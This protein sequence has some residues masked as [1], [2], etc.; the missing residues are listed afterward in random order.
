M[1]I[2]RADQNTEITEHNTEYGYGSLVSVGTMEHTQ[3]L[4]MED[5]SHQEQQRTP[6]RRFLS[7]IGHIKRPSW[8]R[9]PLENNSFVEGSA[10]LIEQ[11]DSIIS[12]EENTSNSVRTGTPDFLKFFLSSVGPPQIV[13]LCMLWALALGSTIGVVP[14]VLTDQYAKIYHNFDSGDS[15]SNYA[16][17]DKPHACLDGSSDAQTAAASASFVSNTFTFITSSLIGSISDEHGRRYLL[18]LGNF[19]ALLGPVSLVYIQTFPSSNPNWYYVA[20]SAG[21]VVSWISLA[22]SSLSDVMPKQWRAPTFGLLL[23][24]FSVGFALSPVLALGFSHY[25]VSLLSLSLLIGGFFYSLFY[26]PETLSPETAEA[27]RNQRSEYHRR[28]DESQMRCFLRTLA[29]PM[30]ELSILNRNNLFRLLSSLAFFSGMTSSADQTLLLYYVEDRLDFNDHDVAVMFGLIGLLGIFVQG[31]M[32]KPFTDLIGERLV[33]VVAF[34]MGA[35]TNALYAYAPS[36]Q[37]IFLA[38]CISSFGGMSFPTI[39]AIKANNAEEFEQGRIQGALYALSSLASA[40][41][42]CLLRLGY[43][44]TKDTSQPGAFFLIGSIFFIVATFCGWA[45]PKDKANSTQRGTTVE[46]EQENEEP[47]LSNS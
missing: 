7:G 37:Y 43:Q 26:L 38:V 35:I 41:G 31:F 24:G 12:E 34:I 30:K 45:L 9:A 27:A 8:R 6:L 1:A 29:R 15:C 36:K 10:L 2:D 40:I 44:K 22:L 19:L 4:N 18:I 21:G 46:R 11:A 33:V 32:L 47:L 28:S 25:G 3:E 16:K 23:S 39:S 5:N 42:P 20:S 13:F 14:S 17:E